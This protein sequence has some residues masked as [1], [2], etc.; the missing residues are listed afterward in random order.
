M[1]HKKPNNYKT[2]ESYL[3]GTLFIVAVGVA[4]NLCPGPVLIKQTN[5][6]KIAVF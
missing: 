3:S 1:T 4:Q 6:I 5:K 2:E